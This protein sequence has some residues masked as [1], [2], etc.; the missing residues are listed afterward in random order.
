[1][2]TGSLASTGPIQDLTL[3]DLVARYQVSVTPLKRGAV[4]EA[5]GMSFAPEFNDGGYKFLPFP[6]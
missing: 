2:D 1:M 5:L 4:E 3:I 6:P